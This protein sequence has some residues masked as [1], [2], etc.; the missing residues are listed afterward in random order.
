MHNILI[1]MF[2]PSS[3]ETSLM[4][5]HGDIEVHTMGQVLLHKVGHLLGDSRMTGAVKI[6]FIK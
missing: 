3:K 4:A 1:H 5:Y 6:A 2:R